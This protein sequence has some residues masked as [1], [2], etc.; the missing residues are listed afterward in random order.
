MEETPLQVLERITPTLSAISTERKLTDAL[1]TFMEHDVENGTSFMWGLHKEE[2][3]AIAKGF[4]SS[5]SKF[6]LHIHM[7]SH[8][9]VFVLTGQ[10]TFCFED[11]PLENVLKKGDTIHILPNTPH[12]VIAQEDTWYIAITIPADEAFPNVGT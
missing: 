2:D 5:G 6:P 1:G 11:T 12:S 3:I 10:I 7:Y 4:I 8:E 9:Y